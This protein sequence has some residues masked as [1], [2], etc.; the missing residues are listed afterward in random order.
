MYHTCQYC[1]YESPIGAKFCRQCGAQ[2]FVE[3][4]ASAAGTR[5]YGRQEPA[6]S[7]ATAGSGHLPPSVAD[8]IAGETERYYQASY[9][10]A[11]AAAPTAPIKSRIRSWLRIGAWRWIVLMLVLII[12]M[13]FGAMVR[14]GVR[15]ERDSRTPE[16]RDR[17]QRERDARRRQEDLRRQ[18]R[19]RARE[20][21]NRARETRDRIREAVDRYREAADRAI[22]AGSAVVPTDDKLYD[23]SRY[24]YPEAPVGVSIRIPGHEMLTM[25]TTDSFDAV[26]EYYQKKLGTQPILRDNE[27]VE[28]RVIYQSN[29]VPAILVSVE[30]VPGQAGPEMKI[31]VLRSPFR[32]L[33]TG[34]TQNP[35]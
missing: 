10:P 28:K 15:E 20:A 18:A 12:G 6:P 3:T 9:V 26:N 32:L 27:A 29:T 25:R 5:N 13:A 11:P 4:E 31:V 35:E 24:E 1:S 21:E 16:E 33:R 8:A 2:F 34:E 23:L 17:V 19:D 22:E 30:T 7:V 14:E